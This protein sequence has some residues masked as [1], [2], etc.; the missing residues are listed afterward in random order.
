MVTSLGPGRAAGLAFVLSSV[1]PKNLLLAASA[2]VTIGTAGVTNATAVVAAFTVI[3]STTVAVPVVGF[4]LAGDATSG[5]LDRL[6]VWLERHNPAI[7][8]TLLAGL[9]IVLIGKGSAAL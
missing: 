3:A 9:G 4:M 6:R 2:G 7:M 5:P 1:N 8:G